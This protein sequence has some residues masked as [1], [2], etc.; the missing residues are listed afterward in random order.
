MKNPS[1]SANFNLELPAQ[2]GIQNPV[3]NQIHHQSSYKIKQIQLLFLH[4]LH[5]ASPV[6]QTQQI[7]F[8]ILRWFI[9]QSTGQAGTQ[10]RS[11]PGIPTHLPYKMLGQSQVTLPIQSPATWTWS[12]PPLHQT[13]IGAPGSALALSQVLAFWESTSRCKDL[14]LCLPKKTNR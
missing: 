7:N 10:V 6:K 5:Q 14:P 8:R 1:T 9:I 4:R 11:L 13:D 2:H 3:C 12:S